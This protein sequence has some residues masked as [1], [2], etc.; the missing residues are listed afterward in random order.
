MNK[1]FKTKILDFFLTLSAY[2]WHLV[3]HLKV[4]L[5]SKYIS[6]HIGVRFSRNLANPSL[7]AAIL[8]SRQ[9]V[10]FPEYFL[11]DLFGGVR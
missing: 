3:R 8:A 6:K 10:L 5:I 4:S 11:P 9:M 2:V 7:L 1:L